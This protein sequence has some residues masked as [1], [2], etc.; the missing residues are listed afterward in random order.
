M[1]D[2][3]FVDL[4]DTYGALLTEHQRTLVEGYYLYDLSFQELAEN[5]GGS[6]Q[7]V[8]D[9]VK[10]ARKTL[11]VYEDKLGLVQIKKQV[12]KIADELGDERVSK[13]LID[14]ITKTDVKG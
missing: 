8:Y 14:A 11:S 6:R 7:S 3:E 2:Y 10:K 12:Q 13:K 9:A 1:K 4:Y 5:N